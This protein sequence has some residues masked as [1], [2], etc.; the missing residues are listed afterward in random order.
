MRGSP[1]QPLGS[2]QV[3]RIAEHVSA[4]LTIRS[5]TVE[6]KNPFLDSNKTFLPQI[7]DQLK[8]YKLLDPAVKRQAPISPKIL[9]EML[10]I[11]KSDQRQHFI[12]HLCIGAFFFACRSCEYVITPS[13]PR[14]TI[15]RADDIR[16]FAK[17][18]Q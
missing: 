8:A 10:G 9:L 11:S 14:T 7:K 6:F 15:L 13:F 3:R 18:K 5:K 17:V 1:L 16:F 4:S 2:E 12:T